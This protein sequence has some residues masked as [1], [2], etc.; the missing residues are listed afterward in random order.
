MKMLNNIY[1]CVLTL[2]LSSACLNA[3]NESLLPEIFMKRHSGTEYQTIPLTEDQIQALVQAARWTPSSYND[4]PWNF[5][6]CDQF[7]NPEAYLK[8]V[9]SIYGQEWV[10]SAPL[11]V[12][13][14]VRS[15]FLYNEEFNDWAEYDTGAAVLSMSLAAT[16]LGL[17]AHQI[18]G[19]DREQ[20]QEDFNIPE[21]YTPITITAIG[22][23]SETPSETSRIRRS[24]EENFFEAEWGTSFKS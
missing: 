16:E 7:T 23:E 14:V 2:L 22:Y 8:A 18:G 1:K 9:D 17:M 15:N 6:F 5:I 24:V 13:A 3:Y 19:F 21:G 12:I 11:L 10:E 20:I 4:Q